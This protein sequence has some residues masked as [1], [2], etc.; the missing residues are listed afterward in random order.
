MRIVILLLAVGSVCWGIEKKATPNSDDNPDP[1]LQLLTIRRVYVDRLSG[2]P[3]AEQI[4]DMIIASLQSAKLFVLTENQDRADAILRGSA[5]DLVFTDTFVTSDSIHGNTASSN[6]SSSGEST[7]GA[8]DRWSENRS[9]GRS[10]SLGV[11]ENESS[12]I[13]ERK[14]ESV[15]SVRLVGKNGDVIWSSTQESLGGKFRGASADVAD[16]IM[17]QLV[18]EYNRLKTKPQPAR[19]E[20]ARKDSR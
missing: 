4:R 11:G 15:A 14:H 1:E 8:Y 12:N 17:K 10:L 18:T 7:G 16:K 2:G 3:T 9:A 6:H 20:T 13:R 5:E 19:P